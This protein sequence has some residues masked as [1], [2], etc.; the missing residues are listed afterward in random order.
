MGKIRS[1]LTVTAFILVI[2]GWALAQGRQRVTTPHTKLAPVSASQCVLNGTYRVDVV[3]SDRLYTIV[4]NARSTVPFTDQ[5]QFFMDLSTRLTPPD[6]LAI[7]CKGAYVSVGSSR[8]GKIT[9][10]ADGKNRTERLPNG[11]VVNSK[12]TLDRDSLTFVSVGKM[13]DNVNVAFESIDAGKRLGVTRRIYAKQLLE[14]IVIQ[15]F[16][17]RI[18]TDVQWDIY[19]R[20]LIA[21][22]TASSDQSVSPRGKRSQSVGVIDSLRA[23]FAEWLDATNRRDIAG[24]MR[25]YM[26]ELSAY[27]LSRNTPMTTVR[28]E[29]ERVFGVA[30]SVDIRAGE[31]EIVFQNDGRSAVM[32]FR[33]E[34]RVAERSRIRQGVVIQELRW[35]RTNNGWRIFSERDIRVIR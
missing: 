27:Y 29:K 25:F 6:M 20:D 21:G 9:Y 12:V 17:D 7:E 3:E 26:P 18:S 13:E 23:D 1:Y 28:Q 8:A 32:R 14:P 10:L 24:Q 30:K 33:K 16:Y 4:K 31:P 19:G 34:Y 2:L 22:Q 5:Q 35:Q 15:T 11:G